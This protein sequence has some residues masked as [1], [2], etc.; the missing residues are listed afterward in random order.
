[1]Y[2]MCYYHFDGIQQYPGQHHSTL[3]HAVRM[4]GI[5]YQ[6][7][8][9][10]FVCALFV[11]L[12]VIAIDDVVMS[13]CRDCLCCSIGVLLVLSLAWQDRNTR[14]VSTVP[15]M[16]SLVSGC[17]NL[18]IWRRPSLPSTGWSGY[19]GNISE[20]P[21]LAVTIPIFSLFVGWRFMLEFA[22]CRVKNETAL[23]LD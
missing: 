2:R 18:S 7:H 13:W 21:C 5:C 11:L 22:L 6:P 23:Y 1:M 12:L 9:F 4:Q 16:P 15:A 10:H 8:S 20:S 3:F 17:P 19:T 14:T